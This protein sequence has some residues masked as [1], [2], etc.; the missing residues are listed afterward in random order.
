LKISSIGVVGVG[1]FSV[2]RAYELL[3]GAWKFL[4][5]HSQTERMLPLAKELR[6]THLA[7]AWEYAQL[8]QLQLVLVRHRN[9]SM[10]RNTPSRVK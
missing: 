3:D 5:F 8:V 6:R 1:Y 10:R 4:L 7:G 9:P 2:L